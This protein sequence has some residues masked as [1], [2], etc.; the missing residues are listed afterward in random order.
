MSGSLFA[1]AE[2][3]L[4]FGLVIG[5]GLSQLRAVRRARSGNDEAR[6]RDRGA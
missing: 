6:R 1:L 4:V 3:L 2:P 5:L